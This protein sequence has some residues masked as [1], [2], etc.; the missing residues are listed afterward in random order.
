MTTLASGR[1]CAAR[2]K[3]FVTDDVQGL[4]HATPVTTTHGQTQ[5]CPAQA[6]SRHGKPKKQKGTARSTLASATKSSYD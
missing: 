2:E 4:P 3:T 1:N 6:A 5:K